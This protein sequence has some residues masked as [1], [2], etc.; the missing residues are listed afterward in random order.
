[1]PADRRS[2]RRTTSCSFTDEF[3]KKRRSASARTRSA[4]SRN[5]ATEGALP[6]RPALRAMRQTTARNRSDATHAGAGAPRGVEALRLRAGADGGRLRGR[7]GEVMAL[8]GDNGAGKSTLIKCIAGIYPTDYGRDP[9]RRR[10]GHD[11]RAEG[12]GAPRDRGRLPGPR[13]LRQ[14]RRRPEHVPRPRGARPLPAPGRDRMEASARPRRCKTLS[15]TTI[16][17]MRQNVAGALRRPAPV[18]RGRQGRDV[19]LASVV[20]LDEPTAALGVA[21]TRQVSISSSGSASRASPWSSS[22]TTC[23]T[24]SRSPTRITVLRLG[25]N[26]GRLQ[27][28]RD[29]PAAGGR[30]DHRRPALRACPAGRARPR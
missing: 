24:S 8:V 29:Q 6:R 16:R 22:R 13:A 1:M 21:Q 2:R 25:Q 17:S 5:V 30:G 15:V 12:L 14:P 20:I 4:A 10:A 19:E 9:L 27:A 7:A 28:H 3:L 11:P 26:V 18:G 23:T